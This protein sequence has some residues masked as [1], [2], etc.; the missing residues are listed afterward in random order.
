MADVS[1][2]IESASGSID[3]SGETLIRVFYIEGLTGTASE[4]IHKAFLSPTCPA[5][6]SPHPAAGTVGV[7][8][9]GLK[10]EPLSQSQVKI[11]ATY[12]TTV[13]PLI[14][15]DTQPALA[16]VGGSVQEKETNVDKDGN[17]ITVRYVDPVTG[18]DETVGAKVKIF[19]GTPIAKF[20][21][22][23]LGNPF[24]K[25]CQYQGTV[26]K[27]AWAGL[28]ARTALC[29]RLEGTLTTIGGVKM[30]AVEYEFQYAP[31][32]FAATVLYTKSDGSF[33]KLT[34]ADIAN[35]NGVRTVD[36]LPE[37]DFNLLRLI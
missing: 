10:A 5:Y 16:Q 34:V 18:K 17:P 12:K 27:N 33:P 13:I 15:D 35:E 11:T 23:E 9:T 2:L 37:M 30:Y 32:G 19:V 36:V 1:D 6:G 20:T 25:S 3:E 29:T 4:R 8:C 31:D 28:P 22:N 14:P 24:A 26:N 21:R 7:L